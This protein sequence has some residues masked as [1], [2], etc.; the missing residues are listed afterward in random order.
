MTYRFEEKTGLID[1]T[2]GRADARRYLLAAL[3]LAALL[4]GD[5][6][7]AQTAPSP[8]EVVVTATRVA[9]DIEE[10][11][12]SVTV[13]T[14]DEIERNQQRTMVEVLQAVPGLHVVQLGGAGTQA[15]LFARGA[16]SNHAL[17]LIDGL[18]ANDPSAANGAFNFAHLM[19]ENVERIEIV[20]GPQSTLYGSDAIGT[21]I[22]II[23]RKGSGAPSLTG[24]VEGGSFGTVSPAAG[25][26]GAF[27]RANVSANVSYF[28]TDGESITAKRVRPAGADDERD[29][30]E[31]L[32]ASARLGVALG[33]RGETSLIGRYVRSD[34]DFDPTAEDPNAQIRESHYFVRLEGKGS[35]LGGLW[36]PTA[37]LNFT[38]YDRATSNDPDSLAATS[39]RETNTGFKHKAELQ[40][41]LHLS[42][43][44]TLTV[45]VEAETESMRQTTASDF[46]GFTI[47]GSTDD[48]VDARAVYVQDKI[49]LFDRLS[50]TFGIRRDDHQSFGGKTT[51]RVTPVL[52]IPETGTRIK[53]SYGTGFRAPAL[54]ELFG[55]TLNNFGGT[56]TGNPNLKAEESRGWEAGFDQ[57]M[58]DGRVKLGAVYFSSRTDN[59]VVCSITT[60]NNTSD[61]RTWGVESFL[62][63]DIAPTVSTRIAYNYTRAEDA[64]LHSDLRRRP[65]HKTDVA[66]TWHPLAAA[67]VTLAMES[68]GPQKDVDF[69]T[70]GDRIR[71]GYTLFHLNGSYELNERY[72]LYGRVRNLLDRDYEAADGFAGPGLAAI[73][74]VRGRF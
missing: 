50:G 51:W 48:D 30:Y 62:T 11:G 26:Q 10:V 15:S 36:E 72:G 63:A 52:R 32:S 71:G 14:A 43:I 57:A 41:D 56:F 2:A 21:V 22:N 13:I 24:R 29:A 39:S 58:M 54:F 67:R 69:F 42:D 60:C 61:A 73:V 46:G 3:P 17:V 9:T 68:L 31:N 33:E 64:V 45:G 53:G 49:T 19:P 40:N 47:A 28:Q 12:S 18:E 38:R 70:G 37:A 5:A 65:K 8:K 4:L 7:L 35:F 1:E 55:F 66:V 44:N 59:L 16:N 25:F 27:G 20:R 34:A 74:G 6:A 23:T